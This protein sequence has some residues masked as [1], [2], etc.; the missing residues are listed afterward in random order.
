VNEKGGGM[1]SACFAVKKPIL[2]I[3]K[4]QEYG[5]IEIFDAK[6]FVRDLMGG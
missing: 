5:D 2:Y 6:K 4:G 1:L 3:G